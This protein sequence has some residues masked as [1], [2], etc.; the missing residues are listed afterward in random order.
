MDKSIR[1]VC[2]HIGKSKLKFR[3]AVCKRDTNNRT[4]H[5]ITKTGRSFERP[6]LH[7]IPAL[8]MVHP[9]A[10]VAQSTILPKYRPC[11]FWH[12]RNTLE[13]YFVNESGF[14]HHRTQDWQQH[15]RI[16]PMYPP[17]VVF[18]STASFVRTPPIPNNKKK[19]KWEILHLKY[20]PHLLYFGTQW[21][22]K[23]SP[24]P[25]SRRTVPWWSKAKTFPIEMMYLKKQNMYLY[26]ANKIPA[27][28]NNR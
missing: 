28:T 22:S 10:D 21:Q 4:N 8:G 3:S 9:A 14:L 6:H 13:C 27:T 19:K 26:T 5:P 17:T 16:R 2:A 15:T 12:Q 23:D 1:F 7:H 11:Y 24:G 20:N 18:L 25:N